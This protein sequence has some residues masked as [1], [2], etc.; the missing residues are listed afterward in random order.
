MIEFIITIR[1]SVEDQEAAIALYEQV[2]S[3]LADKPGLKLTGHCSNHF[4]S[5][6]IPE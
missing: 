5:E 6:E 3:R 1:K 2:K 4:A